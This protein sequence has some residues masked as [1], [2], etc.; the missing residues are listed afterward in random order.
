MVDDDIVLIEVL[1]I[2]GIVYGVSCVIE[3]GLILDDYCDM[4]DWVF[5]VVFGCIEE[6]GIVVYVLDGMFMGYMLEFY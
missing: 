4:V 6:I 3:L 1:V 2:V 5:G